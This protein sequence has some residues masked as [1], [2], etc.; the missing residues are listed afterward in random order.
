M[1]SQSKRSFRNYLISRGLQL[2]VM[3]RSLVYVCLMVLVPAGIILYPLIRDMVRLE[4]AEGQYRAAQ[5]LLSVAQWLIPAIL[6]ILVLFLAHLI[7]ITHRI[8]G[9]LVNFTHTFD[10]LAEG[11]LTRRVR[12]RKGDYLTWEGQRINRMIDG[13]SEI[14]NRLL[15]NHRHLTALLED[16][17]GRVHDDKT[18]GTIEQS[19]DLIRQEAAYVSETLGRFK[20]SGGEPRS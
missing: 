18:M 5:T 16:L 11:D 13:L 9:P 20:T 14:V 10:R 6:L 8:C 1:E 15:T 4:D 17:K 19:L 7:V 2:R 12:L 3:S